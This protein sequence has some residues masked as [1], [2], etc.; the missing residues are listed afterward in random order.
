MEAKPKHK[1]NEHI[2]RGGGEGRKLQYKIYRYSRGT[3]MGINLQ[4]RPKRKKNLPK[5]TR[6]I[7]KNSPEN[8]G[9]SQAVCPG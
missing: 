8:Q 9:L 5:Y 1:K 3:T 7:R 4:E 6:K 2:I